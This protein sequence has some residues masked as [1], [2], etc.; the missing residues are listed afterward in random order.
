MGTR[1]WDAPRFVAAVDAVFEERGDEFV[2]R[3]GGWFVDD[4]GSTHENTACRY[5]EP[6]GEDPD[7]LTP[8][9]LFGAAFDKLGVAPGDV[10]EERDAEDNITLLFELPPGQTGGFLRITEAANRAQT[11]QDNGRPYRVVR[12]AWRALLADEPDPTEDDAE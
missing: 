12:Q 9:C 5:F 3:P 4:N 8:G 1:I 2:Y 10:M 11:L 7:H 6:D